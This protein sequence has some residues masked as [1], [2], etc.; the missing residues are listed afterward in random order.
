MPESAEGLIHDLRVHQIELEM[1][2]D[3]LR[4]VQDAL[5]AS[6]SRYFDLY[7]LAPVGYLTLGEAGVIEEANLATAN[8]L[9]TLCGSLVG[10]PL[11]RFILPEDQDIY[12]GCRQRL[13]S[14]GE[15]Q[16]CELR[17]RCMEAMPVW[18]SVDISLAPE[19]GRGEHSSRVILIDITARKQSEQELIDTKERLRRVAAIA[20]LT[21]W[22][23]DTR[24]NQVFFPPEWWQQTGYALGELPLRL[25]E[26]AALLH[27]ED[28]ERIL[29]SLTSFAA[30]HAQ[31]C[32]IQ[33]RLRRKDGVYRWFAASLEAILDAGGALQHVLL[34]HQD[35]TR[36]KELEDQAIRLA[37]HDPLTGLPT[38]AL[39]HQ[40]AE[41][42]LA[43]ARRSGLQLA[44]LFFDLDK[45]KSVNDL[46][47][48]QVGDQLL[49][50]VARRL[51]DA[52]RAEDLVARIGGDEFVAVLANISDGDNAARGARTAIEALTPVHRIAGLEL[53]SVPS[54]G[55][56]LFPQD[57]DSIDGLI[58]RADVAMYHAKQ[59]GPGRYQ[60]V[61]EELNQQA[62]T[63]SRLESRLR[64][65]LR[66]GE[67]QLLYQPVLDTQSGAVTGV[68]ALLR[69][70]PS[71]GGE[72]APLTFLPVAESCGLIHELGQWVF[73]EACRQH[74]EWRNS[75]LPPIPVAVNV[76]ARQFHHQGFQQQVALASE[77]AG[78]ASS[79]L[80]LEVSEATLM[81]D[82]TASQ[83]VLSELRQLGVQVALD[84]FGMGYYSLSELEHLPLNRLE[85][86]RV[87]VQRLSVGG[88][89]PAIV[90]AILSLGRALQLD[91]TAVGI[92]TE[93][94]LEF[95]RHHAC[96][97]VQGFYLG[98]PMTGD[99][100]TDWYRQHPRS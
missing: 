98:V 22:E 23:W 19:T 77:L 5:E 100:F 88:R 20:E 6:R 24:T 45:F 67:F 92:E 65:G 4:R 31:P 38:R 80:S 83:R 47:G 10:Q 1:Q 93:Q 74:G 54:I 73:Q 99:H 97:Q 16:A 69:W 42:M 81:Q 48:H 12:Y 27:P 52:F 39:L 55:I 32:K 29:D 57:G 50:A 68:E 49:Q 70:R 41:H 62:Q 43:S 71:D 44:V 14:T 56:S 7:D 59:T 46:Y 60:F 15:R 9:K 79:A 21:F 76:S 89:M 35:V 96:D 84:D 34:V 3:E 66:Q 25:D 30:A 18:C 63:A 11:T 33:Y 17:L 8:L 61:T 40:L 28:R 2:N 95:F 72:V 90:N 85:I 87:L 58:Q 51:R 64:D 82:M 75:G 91:I 53:H 26:W 36:R 86:N 78:V 94:E 13:W 37:Q